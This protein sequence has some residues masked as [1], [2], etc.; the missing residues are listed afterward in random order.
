M[1]GIYRAGSLQTAASEIAKYR[2]DLVAVQEIRW[3]DGGTEPA[4]DGSL[5]Y[6]NLNSCQYLGTGFSH[7]VTD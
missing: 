7:Y 1:L 2:L 4:E 5:L 6:G 3:S